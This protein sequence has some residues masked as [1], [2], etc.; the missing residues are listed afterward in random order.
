M[1][2]GAPEGFDFDGMPR[3]SLVRTLDG[4]RDAFEDNDG[5]SLRMPEA[6]PPDEEAVPETALC[7]ASEPGA[8]P[9]PVLESSGIDPFGAEFVMWAEV[10]PVCDPPFESVGIAV[11]PEVAPDALE[12]DLS[13]NCA[14]V[15]PD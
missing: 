9:G 2:P 14:N 6:I 13:E 4:I 1:E 12:D 8:L 11:L 7:E 15:T 10:S 5:W 3:V